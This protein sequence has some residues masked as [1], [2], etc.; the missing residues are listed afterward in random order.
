MPLPARTELLVSV[1][2]ISSVLCLLS[3]KIFSIFCSVCRRSCHSDT[4]S[5]VSTSP[6]L[7]PSP[8]TPPAIF[9]PTPQCPAK[10]PWFLPFVVYDT[11]LLKLIVL[12]PFWDFHTRQ[13]LVP[14]N[15]KISKD[16]INMI[17]VCSRTTHTI[18]ET[19]AFNDSLSLV[20]T[21]RAYG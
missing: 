18:F 11:L 9:V 5:P 10:P 16:T 12:N 3:I 15:S 8:P 14:L 7:P 4:P 19:T 6:E 13:L 2:T 1:T 20:S 17:F 21:T